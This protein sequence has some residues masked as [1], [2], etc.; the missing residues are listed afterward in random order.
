MFAWEYVNMVVTSRCFAFRTLITPAWIWKRFQVEKLNKFTLPIS[1]L[2]QP[3]KIFRNMLCQFFFALA[4]ILKTRILESIFFAK[5]GLITH[6]S[7]VYKTSQLVRIS[8]LI[9][10]L[11]KRVL[12]FSWK[13]Y[14][15][16][17]IENFFSVFAYPDINT[18]RVGRIPDSYANPRL[19]LG[20]A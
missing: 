14:F 16:K 4:D 5:Q 13:S 7:F 11:N 3:W 18:Q 8:L 12:L 10:A 6:T 1:S 20:F 2:A 9:N 17:A 19:C 15:I